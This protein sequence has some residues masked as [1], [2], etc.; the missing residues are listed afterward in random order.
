VRGLT[1]VRA[2]VVDGDWLYFSTDVPDGFFDRGARRVALGGGDVTVISREFSEPIEAIVPLPDKLLLGIGNFEYELLTIPKEGGE[3]SPFGDIDGATNLV[4]ADGTLYYRTDDGICSTSIASPMPD[5]TLNNEF[6]NARLIL[7]GSYLYYVLSGSY[8]RQPIAGGMPEEVQ[9][10]VDTYAW[11]RS[12]THVI[13]TQVDAADET[14]AHVLTMPI[15][16]GTPQELLTI[17]ANEL[18][19][20]A[21]DATNLYLAVGSSGAGAI[22]RVPLTPAAQ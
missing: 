9:P 8:M 13:L 5:Q 3:V 12:P 14:V 15:A 19:A 1:F 6:S 16:G 2:M 22:L 10:L 20:I 7:E 17:E 11:G 4:L 18:K 21:A